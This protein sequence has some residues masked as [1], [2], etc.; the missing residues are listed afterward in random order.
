VSL[1]RI[2]SVLALP[3]IVR[4]GPGIETDSA[5]PSDTTEDQPPRIGEPSSGTLHKSSRNPTRK[6]R[7]TPV[8]LIRGF[9]G[10]N[11][12]VRE[13]ND[14]STDVPPEFP[15]TL[16]VFVVPKSRR[17]RAEI[18]MDLTA[19]M[20]PDLHEADAVLAFEAITRSIG[21]SSPER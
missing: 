8:G 18:S 16:H 11:S 4:R 15:W 17:E 7:C 12:R 14:T 19:P 2:H 21:W 1:P 3:A 5:R 13:S 20:R 9:P 6:I 10:K